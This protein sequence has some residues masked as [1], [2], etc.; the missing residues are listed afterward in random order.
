MPQV[1]LIDFAAFSSYVLY[2]FKPARFSLDKPLYKIKLWGL[3]AKLLWNLK[4]KDR[5]TPQVNF[6]Q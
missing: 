3:K 5:I 1:F 2:K 4:L 6:F